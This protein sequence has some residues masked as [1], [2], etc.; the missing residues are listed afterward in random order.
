MYWFLELLA[1]PVGPNDH[2]IRFQ[3]NSSLSPPPLHS[4]SHSD[5]VIVESVSESL[6]LRQVHSTTI[7]KWL[8]LKS[9]I[10]ILITYILESPFFGLYCWAS[11]LVFLLHNKNC[12]LI[13]FWRTPPQS[14]I[15][16]RL[17]PRPSVPDNF[18]VVY[19][20]LQNNGFYCDVFLCVLLMQL[21]PGS[22]N[23]LR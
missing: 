5:I 7:H 12:P 22:S 18:E 16:L 13:L 3:V 8:A 17:C 20:N 4:P 2:T 23:V 11:A 19:I 10:L 21:L 15:H 9:T 1:L 6:S 14:C